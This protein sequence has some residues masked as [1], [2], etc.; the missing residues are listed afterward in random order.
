MTSVYSYSLC[1]CVWANAHACM[2]NL[3]VNVRRAP[4]TLTLCRSLSWPQGLWYNTVS[5]PS[6]APLGTLCT[7]RGWKLKPVTMHTWYFC[8]FW[9]L[10]LWSFCLYSKHFNCWANS[11]GHSFWSLSV[12]TL[13]K[14]SPTIQTKLLVKS[15]TLLKPKEMEAFPPA[16][17]RP[18]VQWH[19]QT[20]LQWSG[21]KVCVIT[22]LL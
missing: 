14:D 17:P 12:S 20:G 21:S 7:F 15:P 8:E 9:I 18:C 10:E 22:S 3:K 11:A 16:S 1:P 5:L 6:Q 13:H 19:P 4:L 2:W